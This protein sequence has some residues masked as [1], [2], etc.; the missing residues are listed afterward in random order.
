MRD[1]KIEPVES[2]F[3]GT[4]A[5]STSQTGLGDQPKSCLLQS[6]LRSPLSVYGASSRSKETIQIHSLSVFQ[7]QM[8][9]YA[10]YSMPPDKQRA[11]GCALYIVTLSL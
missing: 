4:M 9:Y 2:E 1:A 11:Q 8:Q 7:A 3:G 5:Q 6:L 10:R